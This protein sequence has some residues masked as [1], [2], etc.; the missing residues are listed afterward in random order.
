TSSSLPTKIHQPTRNAERGKARVIITAL[1]A[2]NLWGDTTTATDAYVK[3]FFGKLVGRAPVILNNDNP[4]WKMP[5]DLGTLVLSDISKLKF[6]VW[7]E[8]NTWNDDLL[9]KCERDLTAG[10]NSGMCNLNNGDIHHFFHMARLMVKYS[11]CFLQLL[12]IY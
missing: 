7:D 10:I 4:V 5:L 2:T 1:R 3:V 8:D 12:Y 11:A 6:E 9:G